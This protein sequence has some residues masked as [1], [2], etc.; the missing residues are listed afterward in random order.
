M[1][2][3][4]NV[5]S[6]GAKHLGGKSWTAYLRIFIL[7]FLFSFIA[8]FALIIH[9]LIGLLILL[10]IFLIVVYKI[11]EIRSY[12]LYYDDLGVWLYYGILPWAKGVTGVKWR[13]LD[14]A[15]FVPSFGGW[16]FKSYSIRLTHRYTKTNEIFITDIANGKQCI[17]QINS[18][19][20]YLIDEKLI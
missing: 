1:E 15:V 10:I 5:T 9:W 20:K 19:H 8:L 2:V 18:R 4:S 14:E 12:K 3:N 6:N 13:D 16:L 17:I 7:A 11:M